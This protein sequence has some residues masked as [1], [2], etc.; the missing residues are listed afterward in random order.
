MEERS[1]ELEPRQEGTREKAAPVIVRFCLNEIE[2]HFDENL[3]Y[4]REQFSMADELF[5]SGK[6][7]E[8]RNIWRAQI[9]FLE[10]AFDFYL[11]ELTKFGLSEMFAETGKKRRSITIFL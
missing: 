4:I 10:S 1:L 8:S 6:E 2:E 3:R 9:V 7:E 11:H 5:E